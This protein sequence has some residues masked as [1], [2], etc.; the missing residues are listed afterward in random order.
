MF[1]RETEEV[2]N[3]GELAVG[4]FEV[5]LFEFQGFLESFD[6]LRAVV[7]KSETNSTVKVSILIQAESEEI[8]ENKPS[9]KQQ[10]PI[11]M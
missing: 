9:S 2:V 5:G 10:S 11:N 8:G 4:F 1:V 7:C 3:F 6:G